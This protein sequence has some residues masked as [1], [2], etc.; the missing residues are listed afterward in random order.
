MSRL[1]W[2]CTSRAFDGLCDFIAGRGIPPRVVGEVGELLVLEFAEAGTDDLRLTAK[3]LAS[4]QVIAAAVTREPLRASDL[5]L[6][7]E[8]HRRIVV[9][10]SELERMHGLVDAFM[11]AGEFLPR[12]LVIFAVRQAE[13]DEAEHPEQTGSVCASHVREHPEAYYGDLA[14]PEVGGANVLY[15]AGL[16]AARTRGLGE[17][18]VVIGRPEDFGFVRDTGPESVVAWRH[19]RVIAVDAV[20]FPLGS[21]AELQG[22]FEQYDVQFEFR[23]YTEDVDRW[24]LQGLS[25][26][27]GLVLRGLEDPPVV[28]PV[29]SVFQQPTIGMPIQNLATA[30]PVNAM[31][32]AGARVPLVLPAWCLNRS[33]AAP[34]GPMTPTPLV[35]SKAHG[36]QQAVWADIE[37]RY[38]RGT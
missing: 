11:L 8:W 4:E 18:R 29:G 26:G 31:V 6:A 3:L 34:R 25:F 28:I 33:F 37:D 17:D 16:E 12:D 20:G 32:A 13:D 38:R 35:A 22:L 23:Q 24:R 1:Y 36:S 19:K 5:P 30:Q 14:D 10:R 9:Q 2:S 15:A 7:A 27:V 21:E